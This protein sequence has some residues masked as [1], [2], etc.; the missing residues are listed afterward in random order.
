MQKFWKFIDFFEKF[1]V[2]SLIILMLFL[3]SLDVILR[4]LEL[5][6]INWLPKFLRLGVLW[7]ALL[8]ALIATKTNEHIKV[9]LI[10]R[11]VKNPRILDIISLTFAG[12]ISFVLVLPSYNLVVMTYEFQDRFFSNIPLWIMQVLMPI[13]FA[14]MGLR[15]FNLAFKRFK[16]Q[17]ISTQI[18]TTQTKE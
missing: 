1:L 9:D 3:A 16:N 18:D 7:L 10:N 11:M 12:I 14:L 8:G 17:P 6:G 15:F 4:F 5:G 2:I 13:T